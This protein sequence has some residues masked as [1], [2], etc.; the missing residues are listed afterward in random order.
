[1]IKSPAAAFDF[2]L[3]IP[4]RM[5]SVTAG[6]S[7]CLPLENIID[8]A[9][10]IDVFFFDGYGVLNVG[11]QAIDHAVSQIERLTAMGKAI[12]VVTNAATQHMQGLQEKYARLGFSF[13]QEQIINSREVMMRD[14]YNQS[15]CFPSATTLG[16]IVPPEFRPVTSEFE[17]VYPEQDEFW[18]ADQYLFLSGNGWDDALQSLWVE[19]LTQHPRPIWLGNADLIAPLE[20]GVSNE[21]GS[22]TLTLDESLFSWVKCYGKPFAP[23]FDYVL[24]KAQ[25]EFGFTNRSR[26][27]MIGDTL[28][29]DILGGLSMGLKTIL[30]TGHGFLRDLDVEQA[31]ARSQ[32]I[33]DF[34]LPQI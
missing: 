12:Y 24:A 33:P 29:T 19:A 1:M 10:E 2:Y 3:T 5:P 18:H 28:H 14:F 4:E 16:V 30:V 25:K 7:S 9:D 21:P 31:I 8:V 15:T 11:G 23:I 27:A 22:Y 34:K 6:P 32:I 26:M 13:S 20:I 17:E